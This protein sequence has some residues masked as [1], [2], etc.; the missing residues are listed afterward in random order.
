MT[1]CFPEVVMPPE[2]ELDT[3]PEVEEQE[4]PDRAC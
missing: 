4:Y 3:T 2:P 1:D